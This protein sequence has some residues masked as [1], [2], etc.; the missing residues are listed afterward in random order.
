MGDSPVSGLL[1][2]LMHTTF[3][4]YHFLLLKFCPLCLLL[5]GL[6]GAVKLEQQGQ[7]QRK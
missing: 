2:H 6:K 5:L 3:M 4:L 1:V 7:R